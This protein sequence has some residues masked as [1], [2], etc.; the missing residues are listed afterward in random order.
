MTFE[1]K[2]YDEIN[3][4]LECKE[5]IQVIKLTYIRKKIEG[6]SEADL[7]LMKLCSKCKRKISRCK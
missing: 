5:P 7:K 2:K 3:Q 4:C 6:I 1:S